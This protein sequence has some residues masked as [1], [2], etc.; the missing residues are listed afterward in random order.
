MKPAPF[1]DCAMGL[2][3]LFTKG[4]FTFTPYKGHFIHAQGNLEQ[5]FTQSM[6][7][8]NGLRDDFSKDWLKTSFRLAFPGT[9]EYL[10]I[11][12]KASWS[13]TYKAAVFGLLDVSAISRFGTTTSKMKSVSRSLTGAKP[14]ANKT[15][16]AITYQP[17]L[18]KL[19]DAR[20]VFE[21]HPGRTKYTRAG[22]ALDK[23]G[24]RSSQYFPKVMGNEVSKN[25]QGQ[26]CLEN[27]LNHHN[28]EIEFHKKGWMTFWLP[29]RKAGAKF[30]KNGKFDSFREKPWND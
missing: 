19:A 2:A 17:D 27:I 11:N 15:P 12:N 26:K 10:T 13:E 30:D 28:V 24:N 7:Y 22:H 18:K 21:T 9:H 25:E 20:K 29:G 3:G 5:G 23:H 1:S 6:L 4:Q 8:Y 14:L 16:L